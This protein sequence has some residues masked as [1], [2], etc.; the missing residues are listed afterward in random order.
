MRLTVLI[1]DLAIF[2]P[3][4][5]LC[6]NLESKKFSSTYK[7]IIINIALLCPPFIFI[8]HG[9]FQYNCVML[10]LTLLGVYFCSKKM[11]VLGSIFYTLS[12]NFK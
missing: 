10:G 9:H 4:I 5:I 12:F 2:I 8:D 3:S 11:I 1:L 6:V 7:N